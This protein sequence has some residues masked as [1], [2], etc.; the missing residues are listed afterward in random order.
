MAQPE[1]QWIV[2]TDGEHIHVADPNGETRRI[3]RADLSAVLI[4]TNDS[5][6]WGS[7]F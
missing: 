1:S 2:T 3:A 6:P 5:G 7:D 4:E